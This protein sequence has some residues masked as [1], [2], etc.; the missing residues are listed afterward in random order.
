MDTSQ[1]IAANGTYH[2]IVQVIGPGRD[3]TANK[4]KESPSGDAHLRPLIKELRKL[5][6]AGI[7]QLFPDRDCECT[8][9]G[10]FADREISVHMRHG[11]IEM[12]MCCLLVTT[13]RNFT[14]PHRYSIG[15]AVLVR[16]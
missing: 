1:A 6:P 10:N 5:A 15:Q 13:V 8:S 11:A 7:L 3:I 16:L 14:K 4:W 2:P 9:S 12:K